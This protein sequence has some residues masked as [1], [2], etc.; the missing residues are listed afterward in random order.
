M[1]RR[2]S[3]R[4][5]SPSRCEIQ[6]SYAI[7][8]A[9]PTSISVRT[10]GTGRIPDARLEKLVAAHFDLRP[11]GIIQMLD[12]IH[13]MYRPTAAYGH[14][15]REPVEMDYDWR[16]IRAAAP[17]AR[18]VHGLQ[19][20]AHRPGR[21]PAEGRRSEP[22]GTVRLFRCAE[23]GTVPRGL[24]GALQQA[25]A[26]QA[27]KFAICNG[28]LARKG[29]RSTMNAVINTQ[30]KDYHVADIGLADWGRQEIAIA[31]TEMP[32]LM[33]V[34]DEFGAQQAAR[35]RAH[36]GLAAHDDPDRGADRDARRARRR[37]ALGVLQHLLD[38]GPRGRRDRRRAASRCSPTRARRSRSTGTSR[39]ASSSGRTASTPT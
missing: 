27:R 12:L 22:E 35:R 33:A 37:R 15:G 16:T 29:E 8:V 13:P 2:T 10:F 30:F 7:G 3:S 24:R 1:S 5:A 21:G 36:R 39:I 20:G 19:L 14:F 6:V 25:V 26:C 17:G 28:A 32:G 4:P 23:K 18:P 9:R 11:F 38:A 31:E 34:R